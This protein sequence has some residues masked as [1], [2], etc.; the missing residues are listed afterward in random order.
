[1]KNNRVEILREFEHIRVIRVDGYKC[2]VQSLDTDLVK[3]G[4][5]TSK[6]A[7]TYA[8]EFEKEWEISKF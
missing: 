7:M 4:W 8:R 6:T 1:M 5:K 3:G 2:Y